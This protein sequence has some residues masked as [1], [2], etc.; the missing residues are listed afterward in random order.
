M[1]VVGDTALQEWQPGLGGF[2][3]PQRREDEH[4]SN[5]DDRHHRHQDGDI[6]QVAA[7]VVVLL[8]RPLGKP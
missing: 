5:E 3:D 8:D 4:G 6:A 1:A 2:A 7:D